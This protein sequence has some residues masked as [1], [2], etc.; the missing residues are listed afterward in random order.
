MRIGLPRQV[1]GG[2]G[3]RRNGRENRRLA[4]TRIDADP[5]CVDP[6]LPGWHHRGELEVRDTVESYLVGGA[7]RIADPCERV[8]SGR[9]GVGVLQG[10]RHQLV[11]DTGTQLLTLRS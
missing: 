7:V 6:A 8:C 11:G 5:Y 4:V 2:E 9:P 1:F 10:D 3:A